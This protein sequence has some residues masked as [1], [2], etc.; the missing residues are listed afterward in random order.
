MGQGHT[1]AEDNVSCLLH[2]LSF[3]AWDDAQLLRGLDEF[4]S[5][6]IDLGTELKIN[7]FS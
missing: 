6:T 3:E 4:V 1:G 7:V 2:M 5:F